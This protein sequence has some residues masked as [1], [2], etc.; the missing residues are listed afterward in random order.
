MNSKDDGQ[1]MVALTME[2]ARSALDWT[3]AVSFGEGQ[4]PVLPMVCQDI[5]TGQVLMLGYVSQD[6]LQETLLSRRAVFW[7]RSRQTRWMKGE[8]SGNILAVQRI[9]IDCDGD[10]ILALVKPQGPTCHRHS[11][12]CFDAEHDDGGFQETAVGWSVLARLS[13]TIEARAAGDDPESYTYKLLQ[14]GLDRV[15]RKLGEECTEVILA[16]KNT[17]ITDN[18]DEFCQE[19]ADLLYHWLVALAAVGKKPDDVLSVLQSREGRPRR[20]EMQKL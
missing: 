3:K 20:R 2:G 14:A 19:S 7:S 5:D 11:T 16:A 12:T 10:S 13:R 1:S 18:A 15:L 9:F 6:S 4:P 17:T 8:S